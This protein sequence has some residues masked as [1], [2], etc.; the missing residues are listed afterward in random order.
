MVRRSWFSA[1]ALGFILV[2]CAK[3]EVPQVPVLQPQPQAPTELTYE[4]STEVQLGKV[5]VFNFKG[6][7]EELARENFYY[8]PTSIEK[9]FKEGQKFKTLVFLHGGGESTATQPSASKVALRY[10]RD[11][12]EYAEKNQVLLIFPTTAYGWNLQTRYYLRDLV[13]QIQIAY[14]VDGEKIVLSGHSMGGMGITREFGLIHHF[15]RGVLGQAAGAKE[16]STAAHLLQ[17][18]FYTPYIHL[19]GINDHFTDFEPWMKSLER[20]LHLMEIEQGRNSFFELVFHKGNHQ[21]N[22]ELNEKFLNQLFEQ[23]RPA[24]QTEVY[25]VLEARN[26]PIAKVTPAVKE[27]TLDTVKWLKAKNYPMP[28]FEQGGMVRTVTAKVV[29]PVEIQIQLGA[30]TGAICWDIRT[31]EISNLD[32]L[33]DAKKKIR[34]FINGERVFSAKRKGRTSIDVWVPAKAYCQ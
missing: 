34:V 33:V 15:F 21:P 31:F 19:N 32:R 17:S 23:E 8:F 6:G 29:S 28:T 9:P 25:A 16:S 11:Y 10:M 4:E 2:S 24:V 14:P 5:I 1:V 22:R 27:Q 30:L 13:K 3:E 18:Y 12:L 20:K 26:Y 7:S